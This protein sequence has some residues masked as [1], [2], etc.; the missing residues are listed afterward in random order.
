[1]SEV[2]AAPVAEE[3][4]PEIVSAFPLPPAFFVLY[5]DGVESG[6]PPPAPMEP[7]Y[8]MFGTP[9]STQDVVPDLLPMPGQKLYLPEATAV[10]AAATAVVDGDVADSEAAGPADDAK[11]SGAADAGAIDFKRQLKQI[12]HSLL[13]NFMELV[14]VL[15]QHPALFK[16][17][18]A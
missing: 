12:N 3:A 14:D 1:M 2:E 4:A 11:A 18:G 6:P 9:F 5:R 7:Q 8:H 15:I 17:V 13:A 16:Y 10:Q